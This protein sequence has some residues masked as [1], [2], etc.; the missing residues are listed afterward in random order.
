MTVNLGFTALVST[1]AITWGAAN[2][3]GEYDA[4]ETVVVPAVVVP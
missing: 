1:N 2:A 4:T 3:V